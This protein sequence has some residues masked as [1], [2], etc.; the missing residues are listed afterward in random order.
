MPNGLWV[1]GATSFEARTQNFIEDY[2]RS[3][4]DV[5]PGMVVFDIGANMGMFS[6]E[7]LRRAPDARVF[8]FEPAPETFGYLERNVSALF[9][10]A[11]LTLRLCAVGETTGRATLYHRPRVPVFSS[12]NQD[13]QSDPQAFIDGL[14]KDP[15]PEFQ[16][17]IG[18]RLRRL[19]PRPLI[20]KLLTLMGSRLGMDEIVEIPCEVVTVSQIVREHGVE[21]IDV[22]KVD[23]EGAELDVLRGI[24]EDDWGKIGTVA[25]EVD[26]IGGR[27]EGIREILGAHGFDRIDVTQDWPFEGTDVYML[28]ANRSTDA[29]GAPEPAAAS[30]PDTD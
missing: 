14:L 10:D 13:P 4:L 12:L 1:Y 15:P 2:F 7:L 29:D 9:P 25:C 8:A 3:G 19:I 23:V 21:R 18:M 26:D 20:S 22:L 27:L 6:V 16:N 28:H 5:R 24:E 30:S 17:R 11:A